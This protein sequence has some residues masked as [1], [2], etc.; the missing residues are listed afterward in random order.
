MWPT[1]YMLLSLDGPKS[2]VT[3]ANAIAFLQA[4]VSLHAN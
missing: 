4:I 3:I 2:L 1:P